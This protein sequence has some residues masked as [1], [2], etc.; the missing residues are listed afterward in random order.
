[1]PI[2]YIDA[3]FSKLFSFKILLMFHPQRPFSSC[4]SISYTVALIHTWQ[5]LMPCM[6]SLIN[7][8]YILFL[9]PVYMRLCMSVGT[10]ARATCGAA[11]SSKRERLSS[12]SRATRAL[13]RRASAAWRLASIAALCP[14]VKATGTGKI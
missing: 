3:L 4:F 1:M 7:K 12:S 10:S 6:I 14:A 5:H 2:L 13:A 8:L 9:C 11:C